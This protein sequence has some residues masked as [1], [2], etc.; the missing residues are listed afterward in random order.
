MSLVYLCDLGEI[1]RFLRRQS[2]VCYCTAKDA[3]ELRR[4]LKLPP[5]FPLYRVQ[6]P[7]KLYTVAFGKSAL[8]LEAEMLRWRG[9]DEE[10][11]AIFC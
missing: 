3:S 10:D 6:Q 5:H 2:L 7:G 1:N 9:K 4:S 8:L 11:E